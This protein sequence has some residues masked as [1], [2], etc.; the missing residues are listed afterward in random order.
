MRI[1]ATILLLLLSSKAWSIELK[2]IKASVLLQ[3]NASGGCWT[4]LKETREYAE[5]KLRMKN[6]Q[7]EDFDVPQFV[8][9]EFWLWIQVNAGR[10]ASGHC[11]GY[12]DV[13]LLSFFPMDGQYYTVTRNSLINRVFLPNKNSN[14]VI[15]DH[16]KNFFEEMK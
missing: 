15:L 9:N 5:E 11:T 3:D 7:I 6:I 13:R 14:N 12:T 10:T 1:L 16:V 2:N 8:S 4:N